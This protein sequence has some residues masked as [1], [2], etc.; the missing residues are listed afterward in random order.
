M[1]EKLVD[2]SP[3]VSS[4]YA[5]FPGDIPFSRSVSLDIDSGD[6]LTLSSIHATCHIGAHADAPNHYLRGGEDI[7]SRPLELYIGPCE[8]VAIEGV[9]PRPA[10]VS[11]L[12]AR[13]RPWPERVLFRTGSFPD[14]EQWTDDFTSLS[15]ELIAYL[16]SR[17]VRLVGIDTPSIDPATSKTLAAHAMVAR[18]DMA[19]LEGLVLDGVE[20]G[21]WELIAPPL[22]IEGADAG[23]VRAVLRRP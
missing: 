21:A 10:I 3:L 5:V 13:T 20:L 9:G 4:R 1:S 12:P 14:R 16:G 11:D 18:N 19:I 15:P 23:P 17:G 7:A 6:H 22:K 2:I 8:V